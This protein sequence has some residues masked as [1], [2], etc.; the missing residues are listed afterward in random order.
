[1]ACG[2]G[3]HAPANA[4]V[5]CIDCPTGALPAFGL[6]S[7]ASVLRCSSLPCHLT[8]E[9]VFVAGRFQSRAASG[10]CDPCASG[11]YNNIPTGALFWSVRATLLDQHLTLLQ[12][13]HLIADCSPDCPAGSAQDK[14]GQAQWYGFHAVARP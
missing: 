7:I 2:P 9:N 5:A 3:K 12:P 1:V 11:K 6:A 4:T 14:P 13:L 10:R 8:C